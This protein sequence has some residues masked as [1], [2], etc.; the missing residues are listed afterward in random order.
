MMLHDCMSVSYPLLVRVR[1]QGRY[2]LYDVRSALSEP[3][4]RPKAWKLPMHKYTHI[5]N[6]PK[7]MQHTIEA[8]MHIYRSENRV[9]RLYVLFHESMKTPHYP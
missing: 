1:L 8:H 4:P 3:R 9:E 5:T 7:N 6:T 2:V